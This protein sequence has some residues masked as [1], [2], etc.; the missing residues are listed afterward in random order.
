MQGGGEKKGKKGPFGKNSS[1][2]NNAALRSLAVDTCAL[3]ETRRPLPAPPTHTA[4]FFFSS[5]IDLNSFSASNTR[6]RPTFSHPLLCGRLI[7]GHLRSIGDHFWENKAPFQVGGLATRAHLDHQRR[8]EQG[9][10]APP[11]VWAQRVGWGG[12]CGVGFTSSSN[13]KT[14]PAAPILEGRCGRSC[15]WMSGPATAGEVRVGN[16]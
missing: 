16:V 15:L 12:W 11:L 7:F 9:G 6:N 13:G 14:H 1:N 4:L 5:F 2:H 8:S 3:R 10:A